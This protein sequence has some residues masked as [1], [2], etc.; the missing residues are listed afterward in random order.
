MGCLN[1]VTLANVTYSCDDIPVGGL[2]SLYL[3]KKDDVTITEAVGALVT[4]TTI[5]AGDVVKLDFNNKDAFTAF[6]ENAT[7]NADGSGSVVPTIVVEFPKMDVTK[8]NALDNL[9]NSV[10]S[11]ILAFAE[12]ASGEKIAVGVDFG[13]Y[14]SLVLGKSGN[15]RTDKNVYQLTLTGEE[16][17]LHRDAS[18]VWD[19]MLAHLLP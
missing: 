3:T 9:V 13:L 1:G 17:H 6:D 18:A 10:G 12:L 5:F 15:G 19:E 4:L 8:R 2:K 16:S 14:A 11:E 7:R